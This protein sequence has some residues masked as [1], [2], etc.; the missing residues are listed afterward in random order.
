VRI[1]VPPGGGKTNGSVIRSQRLLSTADV[2]ELDDGSLATSLVRTA[3]DI[4]ATRTPLGG[5]V[6]MAHVRNSDAIDH[7]T[8]ADRLA[9]LGSFPGSARVRRAL[10]R[11]TSGSESALETLIVVRCQ[12]LG[13]RSPEQ[14]VEIVGIDGRPYRVDFG[15]RGG[16]VLLEADGR[17]KYDGTSDRSGQDVLWAEKRREDAIRPTCDAFLRVVWGDAWHAI[18]L[19]RRLRTAAVPQIPPRRRVLTF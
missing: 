3:I 18:E 16:R 12:D 13:F 5:I 8:I 9:K 2:V 11:S 4:A 15:W 1:T 19:E 17:G 10:A 14:Q 7:S 6:A